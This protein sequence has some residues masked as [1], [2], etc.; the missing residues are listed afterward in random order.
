MAALILG[1]AVF[2]FAAHF[3]TDLDVDF[4]LGAAFF[5]AHFLAHFFLFP[6]VTREVA[7]T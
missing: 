3:F 5:G 7:L 6:S 4:I 2:F 1:L